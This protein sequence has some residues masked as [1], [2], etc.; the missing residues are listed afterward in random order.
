MNPFTILEKIPTQEFQPDPDLD[1]ESQALELIDFISTPIPQELHNGK[2]QKYPFSYANFFSLLQKTYPKVQEVAEIVTPIFECLPRDIKRRARKKYFTNSKGMRNHTMVHITRIIYEPDTVISEMFNVDPFD[3]SFFDSVRASVVLDLAE[4]C[5]P[6]TSI[7]RN[8]PYPLNGDFKATFGHLA[9]HLGYFEKPL[10]GR[11]E[12]LYARACNTTIQTLLE[13]G[14]APLSKPNGETSLSL[15]DSEELTKEHLTQLVHAYQESLNCLKKQ[16]THTA[17]LLIQTAQT[18]QDEGS[19]SQEANEIKS[20]QQRIAA[21]EKERNAQQKSRDRE[22]KNEQ[23]I[24][25]LQEQ[26]RAKDDNYKALLATLDERVAAQVK[27]TYPVL[28]HKEACLND[29]I[30]QLE[31][32][33]AQ[34]EALRRDYATLEQQLKQTGKQEATQP[35]KKEYFEVFYD[36]SLQPFLEDPRY[37]RLTQQIHNKLRA[38]AGRAYIISKKGYGSYE[39]LKRKFPEYDL[40]IK[41][42]HGDWR[43]IYTPLENGIHVLKIMDHCTY[44]KTTP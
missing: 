5:E 11:W 13:R 4:R 40:F 29:T 36:P 35:Q 2:K 21:L 7:S 15:T 42:K 39:H 34:N 22:R 16:Q 38:G 44:D 43:I 30:H 37:K 9:H 8:I 10:F 33:K 23:R 20:L 1:K 41:K 24:Q 3:R 12:E 18:I 6:A 31:I 17:H 19:A 26:L 14:I 25:K 32:L 27:S 28:K